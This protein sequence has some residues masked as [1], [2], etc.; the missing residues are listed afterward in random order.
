M[1]VMIYDPQLEAQV[2]REREAS[3]ADRWTEVWDGVTVMPAVPNNEHQRIVMGLATAAL[4]AVD[5]GGGDQV[6][7][8][9][10][11]SDRDPGWKQNYRVPDLLVVLAG[12]R[13]KDHDTH[14][15]G[16]PDF[17][18]EISSPGQDPRDKCDFYGQVG[19]RELLVVDRDP[20]ALELYRLQ[21]GALVPVGRSEPDAPAVLSSAV[22]PLTF[23]LRAGTPRPTI[24][25]THAGTGQ[26]WTG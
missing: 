26:T 4:A 22:L 8:G 5:R 12:G 1:A 20:W 13:A 25:V 10:N 9:A 15:V 18:V 21:N 16:G 7:P 3:P 2:V 19:T 23:E 24:L 17:A 6:L 14:W 11:V